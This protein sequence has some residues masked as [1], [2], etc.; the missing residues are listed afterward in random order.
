[1]SFT[2]T[3]G[4]GKSAYVQ[5]LPVAGT[6][7][8][9]NSL[10]RLPKILLGVSNDDDFRIVVL[11]QSLGIGLHLRWPPPENVS[12]FERRNLLHR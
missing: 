4:S 7:A 8:C 1:M 11:R 10:F 12:I 9:F 3:A 6:S 2:T 5:T